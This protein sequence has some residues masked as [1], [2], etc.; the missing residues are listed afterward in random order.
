VGTCAV[1]QDTQLIA[2]FPHMHL[3]GTSLR[4][5]VGKSADELKEVFKRDPYD[6]DNQTIEK[7]DVKLGAGDVARV[8]CSYD[9]PHDQTI[10]YGESTLNEMCYFIGFAI[11]SRGGCLEVLPPGSEALRRP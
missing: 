8:R 2:G 3:L 7:L 1:R 5:E 11:D 4:F 6:F 10:S 9:N